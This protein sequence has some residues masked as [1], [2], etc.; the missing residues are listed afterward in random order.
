MYYSIVQRPSF[1]PCSYH[2]LIS[3]FPCCAMHKVATKIFALTVHDLAKDA[4]ESKKNFA[5]TNLLM[6]TLFTKLSQCK[7][8]DM[9][10]P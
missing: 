2:W 9:K 6:I 4:G 1:E 7:K 10:I 3:D 5:V 8:F